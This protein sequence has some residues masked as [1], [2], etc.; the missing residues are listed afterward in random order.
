[1]STNQN[2]PQQT[3]T[4][5]ELRG[6]KT[7]TIRSL[8]DDFEFGRMNILIGANGAGKSNFISFFKM[9]SWMTG[10]DFGLEEFVARSGYANSLLHG[11]ARVTPMMEA[12]LTI[13][14]SSGL[15]DYHIRLAHAAQDTLIFTEEKYRFSDSRK[16]GVARWTGLGTGHKGCKL[17]QQPYTNKTAKTIL[18]LLQQLKVYQF[19]NT[20]ET[21]RVRQ[22]WDL[23]VNRFLLED[24]ANL[25][26]FL[27]RLKQNE[28]KAYRRIIETIRQIA[29]FFDD[30]VFEPDYGKV[31]LQWRERGTDLTFGAHQASDGMLRVIAL[32]TL[33]LQPTN[34]LPA[35]IILD[36]PELGLHPYAINIV[37]GLLKSVSLH[38]QVII[39]TQS[40][41]LLD[42]FE[43]E[44]VIVVDRVGRE[45]IFRRLD[46]NKLKDWLEEYSLAELLEKNVIGGNPRR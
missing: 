36:E 28:P 19:H 4:K 12:S 17:R 34:S 2:R 21:A 23:E 16:Q 22:K 45:S 40:M 20:S 6:F 3:L 27:L 30:F 26:P 8:P 44:D 37:A 42:Y 1:M 9:L 14:T 18:R 10:S 5:L 29:P 33:L 46:S 39:A 24:A 15:N 13:K 35:V 43:P 38:A 41:T 25:A 7:M 31:L 32:V 11:G